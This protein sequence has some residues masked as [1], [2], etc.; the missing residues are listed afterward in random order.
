MSARTGGGFGGSYLEEHLLK[1][2]KPKIGEL[3]NYLHWAHYE[4]V[5]SSHKK[6][7]RRAMLSGQRPPQPPSPPREWETFI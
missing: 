5:M 6:R 3:A 7:C 2:R 1:C 4:R